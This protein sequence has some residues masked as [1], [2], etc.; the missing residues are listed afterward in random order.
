MASKLTI[1]RGTSFP[2]TWKYVKNGVAADLTGATVYFTV[3]T[4]QY[5]SDTDD[6]DAVMFATITNHS[7]PKNG[8]TRWTL[9]PAGTFKEP[10]TYHYD[11]L[12]KEADGNVYP[13]AEGDVEIIGTPT[14]RASQ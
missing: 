7:D 12:V 13:A 1:T 8:T 3:K 4:D 14:N 9:T 5:D 2:I 6:S 10:G 11:I